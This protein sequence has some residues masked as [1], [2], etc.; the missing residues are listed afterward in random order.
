MVDRLDSRCYR[1]NRGR[2]G[3]DLDLIVAGRG[4]R[5]ARMGA[6]KR[7]RVRPGLEGTRQTIVGEEELEGRSSTAAGGVDARSAD[8]P[9][10]DG[11]RL[12]NRGERSASTRGVR[13]A[14]AQSFPCVVRL[15]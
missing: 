5:G 2:R 13:F 14:V 10:H 12:S 6:Q 4:G 3:V 7:R 15:L 9:I 1:S 8:G 11:S